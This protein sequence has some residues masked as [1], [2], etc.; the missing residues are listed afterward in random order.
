M[1]ENGTNTET[2]CGDCGLI[3]HQAANGRCPRCGARLDAP[4]SSYPV[5]PYGDLINPYETQYYSIRDEVMEGRSSKSTMGD[6]LVS[7]ENL[8]D[9]GDDMAQHFLGRFVYLEKD[10]KYAHELLEKSAA[11]G[12]FLAEND[13]G[14][15]YA[16]GDCVS[17]DDYAAVR[18]YRKSA[19]KGNPR[20]MVNLAGR[21]STGTG[22]IQNESKAAELMRAAAERGD[23]NAQYDLYNRFWTGRGVE[24]D[25]TTALM[26]C[27]TAANS[28]HALAERGLAMCYAGG[29]GVCKD[30]KEAF[31]WMKRA[32]DNGDMASMLDLSIWCCHGIGTDKNPGRAYYL[33][34]E[35]ADRGYEESFW[36]VSYYFRNG[37]GVKKDI[38]R[39]DKW[40]FKALDSTATLPW[41]ANKPETAKNEFPSRLRWAGED[42]KRLLRIAYWASDSNYA[43]GALK[44]FRKAAALGDHEAEYDIGV[45]IEHGLLGVKRAMRKYLGR[46]QTRQMYR[47]V[48]YY[49][50]SAAGGD[51]CG[52]WK[53]ACFYR[54]GIEVEKNL[55]EAGRLM[56]SA[57]EKGNHWAEYDLA[58][59]MADGRYGER[60]ISRAMG[61]MEKSAESGYRPAL[62][63]FGRRLVEGIDVKQDAPRGMQMLELAARDG[64]AACWTA[65][66]RYC[67][68]GRAI[69]RDY[70]RAFDYYR[71]G[72]EAGEAAAYA[73]LS[74]MYEHGLGCRP[75]ILMA[76]E[77]KSKACSLSGRTDIVCS[78][79]EHMAL[80]EEAVSTD[81]SNESDVKTADDGY[82]VFL[83][84]ARI[85]GGIILL[86]LVSNLFK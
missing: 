66:G 85:I 55:Q 48:E 76:N 43:H 57:A 56:R 13:L 24:R 77:M 25:L 32:A 79:P 81:K 29:Y 10:T 84:F 51:S 78:S 62:E 22:L 34:S 75:E 15:M 31:K 53:L 61:L 47:A 46:N 80:L 59:M 23:A 14:V 67:F 38:E 27:R 26:W 7:M 28:G 33:A 82:S 16:R 21:Y 6:F 65:L 49:K 44:A 73:A 64:N 52:E 58:V 45:I 63:N 74:I 71:L 3:V 17:R 60:D 11:K 36:Q 40:L 5:L 54:D 18:L 42:T 19:E 50:A 12:N 86:W 72:A 70:R 35:V 83:L 37:I 69:P 9:D 4:D 68:L 20:A 8:A 41:Q 39:A 2:R 30:E 1:I